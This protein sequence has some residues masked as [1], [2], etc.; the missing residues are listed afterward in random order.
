MGHYDGLTFEEA[1]ELEKAGKLTNP[2]PVYRTWARM[3][4][5]LKPEFAP[6]N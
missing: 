2:Q 4:V 1:A 3:F 5:R 6:E